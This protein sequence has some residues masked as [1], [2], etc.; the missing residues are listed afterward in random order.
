MKN[1][2][3]R[4]SSGPNDTLGLWYAEGDKI[5]M[6]DTLE[7]EYRKEKVPGETR[8][9]QGTYEIK[10]RQVLSPMTQRYRSK[11]PWFTWHL[12]LQDVP[13]F[14][15]IYVHILNKEDQT[16]GCIGIGSIS[17]SNR[18]DD[19]FIGNSTQT[20]KELYLLISEELNNGE[21]VTVE[22]TDIFDLPYVHN[23][24]L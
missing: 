6:G 13:G 22:I 14:Q 2:I 4:Y 7:D 11:Y 9:P 24:I 20:F 5:P 23:I 21:Q 10:F 8:I 16:D 15:Y 3:I 18:H 12:Q 1:L 17:H 19:G